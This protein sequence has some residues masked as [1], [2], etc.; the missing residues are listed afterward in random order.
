MIFT[1]F[2]LLALIVP[3]TAIAQF[4]PSTEYQVKA[5]Y[6]S[7]FTKF[8]SWPG[9]DPPGEEPVFIVGIVGEDPFGP[10]LNEAFAGAQV[11]G[12]R[13]RVDIEHLRWDQNLRDCQAIFVSKS[14]HKHLRAILTNLKGADVLTVSDIENFS[15][16]GG[17]IEL[18]F[19]VD[20][21]R[22][23]INLDAAN[24]SHLRISSKL[25][26]LARSVKGEPAR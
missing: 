23:E 14:E 18:V 20:R 1:A 21:I 3:A 9:D 11:E 25:L 13:V 16:D 6:L 26:R 2:G 19:D 5:A 10:A 12:H 22:F 17:M 15:S 7:G 8:V 4:Q 24:A